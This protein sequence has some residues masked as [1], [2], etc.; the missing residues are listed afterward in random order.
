MA[1][2]ASGDSPRRVAV[3]DIG[4][5]SVLLL[6]LERGDQVRLDRSVITR[7][8]SGVFERGQLDPAAR[9]RTRATV[10]ELAQAARAAGAQSLVAVG[11]EALRRASDGVLKETSAA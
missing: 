11:T 5:N 8:G 7:L 10:V 9:E 1:N 2:L 3:L 4:S 6:I